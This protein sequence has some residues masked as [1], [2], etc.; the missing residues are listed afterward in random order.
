MPD[1][2]FTMDGFMAVSS[3]YIGL[4]A[5]LMLILA[6]QVTAQRGKGKGAGDEGFDHVQRA[7]GNNT[8]YVPMALL[9]IV[10]LEF[11]GAPFLLLHG[12]GIALTVGRALH[13]YGMNKAPGRTFGRFYGTLVTWLMF[14]VGSVSVLYFALT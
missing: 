2:N 5:L 6:Y 14:L 7:H 11:Q 3:I 12:L 10:A 9:L 1:I 8:E 4:N 13:G